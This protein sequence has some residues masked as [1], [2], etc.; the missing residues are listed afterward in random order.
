MVPT[1]PVGQPLMSGR[2]HS[3]PKRPSDGL[4][5]ELLMD[6]QIGRR[7]TCDSVVVRG[8]AP[9]SP[10]RSV[11]SPPR[12]VGATV[13]VCGDA[14]ASPPRYVASPPRA[15]ASPPRAVGS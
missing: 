7:S 2:P 9:A 12:A 4:G 14:P 6:I 8:G 3:P 5:E 10:P 15:V 13:M 1:P 11:A